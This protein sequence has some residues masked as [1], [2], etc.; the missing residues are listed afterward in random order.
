LKAAQEPGHLARDRRGL[1]SL[2]AMVISTGLP[3]AVMLLLVCSCIL[4]GSMSERRAWRALIDA[5]ALG[6][7]QAGGLWCLV[8]ANHG[9]VN[10]GA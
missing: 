5:R 6:Q 1:T 2:Q 9:G 4:R 8:P 10:D 3:F 7:L